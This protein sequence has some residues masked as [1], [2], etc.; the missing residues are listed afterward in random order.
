MKNFFVLEGID[1]CGKDTIL[2]ELKEYFIQQNKSLKE[3][4]FTYEPTKNSDYGKKFII[5]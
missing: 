5:Y 2:K 1:G 4:E 3:I